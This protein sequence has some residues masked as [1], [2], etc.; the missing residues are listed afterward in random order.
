MNAPLRF[1]LCSTR[2]DSMVLILQTYPR[3]VLIRIADNPINHLEELLPW[4]LVAG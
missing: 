3:E 2:Q 1:T 4:N